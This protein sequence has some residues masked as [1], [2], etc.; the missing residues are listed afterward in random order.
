VPRVPP[1][2]A[3]AELAALAAFEKIRRA[4]EVTAPARR[5]VFIS[6][7][8]QDR[9]AIDYLRA[10][11]ASPD[12]DIEFYDESVREPFD[13]VNAD[14]IRS[15]LRE[16]ISRT[17]VTVCIVGR[18]THA[19]RWVGYELRKCLEKGNTIIAVGLPEATMPVR[20]PRLL[21]ATRAPLMAWNLD[22]LRRAID[23][24]PPPIPIP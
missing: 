14:Y 1:S 5:R 22:D 16:K 19:S 8:V 13:S 9:W 11:A 3:L 24:A 18:L 15:R 12:Y 4:R 23:S 20:M 6:F 2:N 7:K 17:S 21:E 10:A